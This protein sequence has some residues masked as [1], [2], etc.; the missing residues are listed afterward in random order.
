MIGFNH[1]AHLF[2]L[3]QKSGYPTLYKELDRIG[4]KN[5]ENLLGPDQERRLIHY[6]MNNTPQEALKHL[7][8]YPS[9]EK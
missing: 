8:K 7:A 5:L 3:A 6:M 1:V 4:I 2:E 9:E